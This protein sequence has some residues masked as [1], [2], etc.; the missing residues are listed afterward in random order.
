MDAERKN[1]GHY[2]RGSNICHVIS[3]ASSV[4]RIVPVK[5]QNWPWPGNILETGISYY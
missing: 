4:H 3:L 2:S 1:D 5:F